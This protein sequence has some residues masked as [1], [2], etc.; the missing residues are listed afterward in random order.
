[1]LDRIWKAIRQFW[2]SHEFQIGEL[3]R[4][5]PECVECECARCGKTCSA[6]YGLALPGRLIQ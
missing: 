3:R 4:M 2:C 1:M 6:V 5:G